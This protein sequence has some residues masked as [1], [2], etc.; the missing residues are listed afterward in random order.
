MGWTPASQL[1]KG[2][3]TTTEMEKRSPKKSK[4]EMSHRR[5]SRSPPFREQSKRRVPFSP[6]VR[7]PSDEDNSVDEQPKVLQFFEKKSSYNSH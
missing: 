4:H 6:R 2:L 3:N 5:D 7:L 1:K